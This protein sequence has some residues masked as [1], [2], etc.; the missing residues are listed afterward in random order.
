MYS[1]LRAWR[2]ICRQIQFIEIELKQFESYIEQ[3]KFDGRLVILDR[4]K[5]RK[6]SQKKDRAKRHIARRHHAKRGITRKAIAQRAICKEPSRKEL[7]LKSNHTKRH[8]AKSHKKKRGIMRQRDI[9]LF[10]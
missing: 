10:S 5:I 6:I 9:F 4:N 7:S 3:V 2:H 8:V 1:G